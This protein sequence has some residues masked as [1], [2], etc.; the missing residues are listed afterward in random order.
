MKT[1]LLLCCSFVFLTQVS[2]RTEGDD[3]KIA[4]APVAVASFGAVVCGDFLYF[5]GGNAGTAHNFSLEGQNNEFRRI[6]LENGSEWESLGETPRRQGLAL[7]THGGKVYRL[8]GFTAR[9]TADKEQDIISTNEFEVFDPETKQWSKLA[10]LPEP[11]S[12]FDAVVVGDTIYMMGGW[13]LMGEDYDSKWHETAWKY[14]L[15]SDDPQW[16]KLETPPFVRRANS[17]GHHDGTVFVIGG[18]GPKGGPTTQVALYDPASDSW[19]EGPELPGQAMDGFGSSAFNVGGDLIV[20]TVNGQ[21]IKPNDDN[22]EWIKIKQMDAGRFFHRLVAIDNHR[23][24]ILGGTDG[25]TGKLK[26]VLV[27]SLD[28]KD[29]GTEKK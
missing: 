5:Y 27:Y 14:D 2:D 20:S 3:L 24:A 6:K 1:M 19:S 13:A 26:S 4:D 8:G 25:K 10:D 21:I 23:F 18:M 22:T 15:A 29:S 7:V 17:V 16:V 12:S 11:R 9:N 28:E